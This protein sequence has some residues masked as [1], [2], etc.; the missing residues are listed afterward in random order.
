MNISFKLNG[1]VVNI[2]TNPEKRLVTLLRED[3][4]LTGTKYGCRTGMCG[5]CTV[6]IDGEII[7]SC[8]VPVFTIKGSE[9]LTIEGF[10]RTREFQDIQEGFRRVN[11]FPCEYCAPGKI[12]TIHALLELN[13][14]PTEQEIYTAMSGNRCKC[15]DLSSLLRGVQSAMFLREARKDGRKA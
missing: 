11:Y 15:D 3:F 10:S 4:K 14:Q 8:L 13:P 6:L 5:S 1:D 9:V 12:L 7:L 2:D